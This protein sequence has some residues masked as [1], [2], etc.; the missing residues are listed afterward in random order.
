MFGG[1]LPTRLPHANVGGFRKS[2]LT[3]AGGA[4]FMPS[5]ACVA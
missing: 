3:H 2:P 4:G 5:S 1:A